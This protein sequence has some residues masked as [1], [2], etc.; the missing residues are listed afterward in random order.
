MTLAGLAYAGLWAFT[1]L[2]FA[3]VASIA[4]VALAMLIT[5]GYGGWTFLLAAQNVRPLLDVKGPSDATSVAA[6]R[7][8]TNSGS[9]FIDSQCS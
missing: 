2:A 9:A 1:P 5:I 7:P 8:A 6:R 4:V 3:D